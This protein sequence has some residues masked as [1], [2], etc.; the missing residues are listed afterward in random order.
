MKFEAYLARMRDM[1]PLSAELDA[2]LEEAAGDT[3]LSVTDYYR[4]LDLAYPI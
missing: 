1:D 3:E 4:L 2:L